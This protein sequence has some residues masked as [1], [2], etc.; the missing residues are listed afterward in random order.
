M[1][2][3]DFQRHRP[4][5]RHFPDHPSL[6]STNLLILLK[7]VTCSVY[8]THTY[9]PT[10]LCNHSLCV[11]LFFVRWRW[12]RPTPGGSVLPLQQAIRFSLCSNIDWPPSTPPFIKNP[13]SDGSSF[14][15]SRIMGSEGRRPHFI[16][17]CFALSQFPDSPLSGCFLGPKV[18]L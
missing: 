15:L 9:L 4:G 17:G 5:C 18:L 2:D 16:F 12:A 3:S 7:Y 14:T 11:M 8:N 10:H 13:D 6:P 1:P